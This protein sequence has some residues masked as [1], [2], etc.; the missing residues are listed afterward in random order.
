[1]AHEAT[2][3]VFAS[4][5]Q[6]KPVRRRREGERSL[7]FA[8]CLPLDDTLHQGKVDENI[9]N[10]NHPSLKLPPGFFLLYTSISVT[11]TVAVTIFGVF[12]INRVQNHSY[13]FQ[14]VTD[15][16]STRPNSSHV[17]I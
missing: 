1:M 3:E 7:I 16:K 14:L 17:S 12:Q 11:I 13:I 10:I 15:R 2:A 9:I 6:K 5:F 8:P 4:F